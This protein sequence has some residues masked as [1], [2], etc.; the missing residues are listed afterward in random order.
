[1]LGDRDREKR[2]LPGVLTVL[3]AW[4]LAGTVPCTSKK[5]F[6]SCRCIRRNRGVQLPG[7]GA[8]LLWYPF[9]SRAAHSAASSRPSERAEAGHGLSLTGRRRSPGFLSGLTAGCSSPICHSL[10]GPE[11]FPAGAAGS[12]GAGN[13]VEIQGRTR[14]GP[15][16]RGSPGRET[17][18]SGA[19]AGS[20]QRRRRRRPRWR[21]RS[22]RPAT[23]GRPWPGCRRPRRREQGDRDRVGSHGHRPSLARRGRLLI[24]RGRHLIRRGRLPSPR[25]RLPTRRGVRH[26]NR[27]LLPQC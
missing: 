9:A 14:P 11:T 24:R 15:L 7:S 2:V 13:R 12:G 10:E 3:R 17:T 20:G 23:A 27:H 6:R 25:G 18:G 26:H 4:R 5:K 1:M 16:R 22:Q 8:T 19:T 21:D